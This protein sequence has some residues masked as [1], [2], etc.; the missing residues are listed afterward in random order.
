MTSN[1]DKLLNKVLTGTASEEEHREFE[2]ML[3]SGEYDD[4]LTGEKLS[5]GDVLD[6]ARAQRRAERN[7]PAIEQIVGTSQRSRG[8]SRIWLAAAAIVVIAMVVGAWFI[9][10]EKDWFNSNLAE[11]RE[12]DWEVYS[13]RQVITLP[14]G[15]KVTLNDSSELRHG[16][17][18]GKGEI[19]KVVLSGEAT[20]DVAHDASKPF[21]VQTGKVI[22]KVLGTEFNVNAF[23]D[24][25]ITVTVLRGLVEVGDAQRVYGQVR[26]NEQ[27]AVDVQSYQY[28]QQKT[29]AEESVKWKSSFLVLDGVS[30]EEAA[31]IIGKKF[32][33]QVKFENEALKK[34][35]FVGTFLNDEDL[36]DVLSVIGAA[37]RI[38]FDI[39]RSTDT[40]I[41]NG[42]GCN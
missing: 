36:Y 31:E 23:P 25:T 20:F 9:V 13:G 6:A 41:L 18:F 7:Y 22:I 34:C 32:N 5:R 10:N 29:N 37:M 2:L 38:K 27:I 1:F 35:R 42:K 12:V 8:T 39:D 40:V 19:R 26:P 15:S 17:G 28:V 21:L 16:Q 24:Q 30:L 14:D 33:V 4:E 3:R 11:Q